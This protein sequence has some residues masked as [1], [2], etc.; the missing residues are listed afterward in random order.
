MFAGRIERIA[1]LRMAMPVDLPLRHAMMRR[2]VGYTDVARS[3]QWDTCSCGA[4]CVFM[5][6]QHFGSRRRYTPVERA[7]GTDRNGTAETNIIRVLRQ[8][9]LRAGRRRG[10]KLRDLER[11]LDR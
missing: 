6:L 11:L 10:M 2:A 5:A 1:R 8:S 9:G 4:K 3:L 7:L